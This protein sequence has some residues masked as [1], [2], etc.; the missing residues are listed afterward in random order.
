MWV[1]GFSRYLEDKC[2]DA[3]LGNGDEEDPVEGGAEEAG[4][5]RRL[6]HVAATVCTLH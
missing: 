1:L 5:Q 4:Q 2:S 6:T 3:G